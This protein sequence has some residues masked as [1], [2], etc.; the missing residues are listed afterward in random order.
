MR[1][2]P[3]L[4]VVTPLWQDRPA[5][6]NLDVALIADQLGYSELWIGEMATFDAFAFATA[7]GRNAKQLSLTIGP[8]A[9]SVR[10]PTTMAIGIASVAELT[11]RPVRLAIGTSSAVVVEEWHGRERLPSAKWLDESAVALTGLLAGEKVE[12]SGDLVRT[13][14]YRL[15]LPSPGAHLTI[16]AFGASAVRV[17]GRRADRLVLNMV[18][19]EAV[20]RFRSMVDAEADAVGRRRPSIAVWLGA[21]VNPTDE[22]LQQ[23]R[24]SKV[25]YL[26]AP[27][28]AEMFKEAGFG[29]I[30]AF[31]KLRPHPK[32]ILAAMPSALTSAV[33]LVGD[34]ATVTARIRQYREAGADEVCLVPATAGDPA[35]HRTLEALRPNRINPAQP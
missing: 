26:A 9:V 5:S 17:A 11:G 1:G 20:A 24:R 18:T 23:M 21:S 30:V 25:A 29:D 16:A 35:G 27:G 32:E 19:P 34:E 4:S 12:F 7:V 8:L 33:G 14:G 28:Y 2:S 15:R 13:T 31:A 3:L 6:E 22:A 10:T